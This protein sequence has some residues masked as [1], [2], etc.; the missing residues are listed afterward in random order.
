MAQIGAG[1]RER[2]ALALAS[3]CTIGKA[4]TAA[5]IGRRTATRWITD[6]ALQARVAELQAAMVRRALGR[7]SATMSRAAARLRKLIQSDDE[8]VALGAC[9]AVL[10][11]RTGLCESE[12]FERRLAAVEQAEWSGRTT[13]AHTN[14]ACT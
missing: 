14:G 11:L 7:M 3:G 6:R 8:R 4:A 10:E 12:E 5:G 13:A 2:F 9:R 1:K